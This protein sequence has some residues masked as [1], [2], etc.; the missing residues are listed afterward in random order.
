MY[1]IEIGVTVDSDLPGGVS[2]FTY[3]GLRYVSAQK[4]KVT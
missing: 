3:S 1:L 2:V 4:S